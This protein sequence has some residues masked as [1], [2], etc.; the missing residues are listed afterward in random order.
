MEISGIQDVL[1]NEQNV[2]S[3]RPGIGTLKESKHRSL[4][5]RKAST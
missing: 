3:A 4:T 2:K 5:F 1:C